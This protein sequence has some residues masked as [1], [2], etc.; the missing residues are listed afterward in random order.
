MVQEVVASQCGIQFEPAAMAKLNVQFQMSSG[1]PTMLPIASPAKPTSNG[2]ANVNG[3]VGGE[4][5]ANVD[6]SASNGNAGAIPNPDSEDCMQPIHDQL[7]ALPA[8]WLLEII[9]LPFS[10]QDK[11]CVWKKKWEYVV[12]VLLSSS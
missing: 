4:K 2:D 9:P 5:G 7:V 8:W 1:N 12:V 6:A 10:W 3:I 11:N